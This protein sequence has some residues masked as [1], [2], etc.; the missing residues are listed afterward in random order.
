VRPRDRGVLCSAGNDV[1]GANS[2]KSA[3]I[4]IGLLYIIEQVN[5][6]ELIFAGKFVVYLEAKAGLVRVDDLILRYRIVDWNRVNQ[7]VNSKNRWAGV[8]PLAQ[9]VTRI[10]RDTRSG[11]AGY[12]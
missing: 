9:T 8:C 7:A 11:I 6:V 3:T 2:R 5:A 12:G 10:T 4:A 1:G